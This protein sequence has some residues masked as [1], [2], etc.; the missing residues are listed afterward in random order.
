MSHGR[1]ILLAATAGL[2][3]IVRPQALAATA[4]AHFAPPRVT[5]MP[6]HDAV[7]AMVP[8]FVPFPGSSWMSLGEPLA[9]SR[10]VAGRTTFTGQG[11]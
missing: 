5:V 6:G 10:T 9:G 3:P 7:A 8:P 2:W 1:S 4:T 11:L